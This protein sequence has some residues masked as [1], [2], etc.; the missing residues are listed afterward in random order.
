MR[1][2]VHPVYV[3][4]D[5]DGTRLQLDRRTFAVS[6]HGLTR[7]QFS[8]LPGDPVSGPS[9]SWKQYGGVTFFLGHE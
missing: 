5:L 8:A 1:D 9:A 3:Q 6:I 2:Q 4:L 7:D